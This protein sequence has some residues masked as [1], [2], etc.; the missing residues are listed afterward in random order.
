MILDI[1]FEEKT[2][3]FDMGFDE[4]TGLAASALEAVKGV[5]E[6]LAMINEGGVE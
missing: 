3:V 5:E 6:E 2:S 4:T 1:T